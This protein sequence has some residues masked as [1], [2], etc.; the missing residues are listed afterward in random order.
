[1]SNLSLETIK[2]KLENMDDVI[3]K[4]YNCGTQLF[5][6]VYIESITNKNIYK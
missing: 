2:A 4:E 3:Y 1:M 5:T 6:L